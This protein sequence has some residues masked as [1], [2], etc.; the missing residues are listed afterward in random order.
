MR[1]SRPQTASALVIVR[2]SVAETRISVHRFNIYVSA[3]PL[4]TS[5]SRGLSSA[6]GAV[7]A[8]RSVTVRW[9]RV[10][11]RRNRKEAHPGFSPAVSSVAWRIFL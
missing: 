1:I 5:N 10:H 4:V 9:R 7:S 2:P 3:A 6:N 11:S 8:C